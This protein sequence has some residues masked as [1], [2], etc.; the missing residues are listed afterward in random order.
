M[1]C[2]RAMVAV[3]FS[4]EACGETWYIPVKEMET[5]WWIKSEETNVKLADSKNASMLK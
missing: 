3:D 4:C 5:V 1:E 2:I